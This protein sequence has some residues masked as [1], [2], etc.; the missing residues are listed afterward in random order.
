MRT[1]LGHA[2]F[3]VQDNFPMSGFYIDAQTG[4]AMTDFLKANS[5]KRAAE[6]AYLPPDYRIDVQTTVDG[7]SASFSWSALDLDMVGDSWHLPAALPSCL[8]FPGFPSA[9]SPSELKDGG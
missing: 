2:P 8:S 9:K 4:Q 6:W 3:T 7:T 1:R 5:V